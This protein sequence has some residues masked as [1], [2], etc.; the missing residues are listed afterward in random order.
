M[1]LT[2]VLVRGDNSMNAGSE[3]A[4]AAIEPTLRWRPTRRAYRDDAGHP[5]VSLRPLLGARRS[6]APSREMICAMR[7]AR[8]GIVVL[9]RRRRA[10]DASA[11]GCNPGCR[12]SATE[13]LRPT[14]ERCRAANRTGCAWTA[15]AA[16]R[17]VAGSNPVS[18]ITKRPQITITAL[19]VRSSGAAQFWDPEQ[20]AIVLFALRGGSR[21]ATARF[22]TGWSQVGYDPSAPYAEARQGLEASA[23]GATPHREQARAVH[24]SAGFVRSEPLAGARDQT[25]ASRPERSSRR[26][27]S[28]RLLLCASSSVGFDHGGLLAARGQFG[29]GLGWKWGP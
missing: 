6:G 24:A 9:D 13:H 12:S 23:S 16:G 19:L 27:Q 7:G 21:P 22:R 26:H 18:P 1:P 29:F 20:P 2:P 17:A 8:S 14:Q 3:R 25:T 11:A 28:R 5:P 15:P 10:E 4:V